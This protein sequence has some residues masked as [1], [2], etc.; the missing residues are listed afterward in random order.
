M[1]AILF[2][3]LRRLKSDYIIT[4]VGHLSKG[5]FEYEMDKQWI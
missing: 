2:S 5:M 4:G 1:L 3:N